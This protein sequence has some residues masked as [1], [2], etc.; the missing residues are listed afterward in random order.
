VGR[1]A[2]ALQEVYFYSP[3]N[4][5]KRTKTLLVLN[6]FDLHFTLA[7]QSLNMLEIEYNLWKFKSSQTKLC[8][9]IAMQA[10]GIN[11]IEHGA[12]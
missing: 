9:I 10:M 4:L 11:F 5:P 1:V 6:M 2:L 7:C 3:C 12:R 8:S